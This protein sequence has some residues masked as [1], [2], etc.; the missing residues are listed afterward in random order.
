MKNRKW[1]KK[2]TETRFVRDILKHKQLHLGDPTKWDDKNDCEA[3]R[4]YSEGKNLKFPTL[5][6]CL[7]QAPDRFHFW[8][9][10]GKREFG[11]CLW[12]CK[13]TL[14]ADIKADSTLFSNEV[15]Y[16]NEIDLDKT[17]LDQA[18]FTKREQYKDER[19]FRV[20]RILRPSGVEPDKLAF[21][22]AS[23]K[24]I[25][26]NPWLS[27]KE[28]ETQKLDLERYLTGDLEHVEVKQ[29]RC[30]Q[31]KKWIVRLSDAVKQ[32]S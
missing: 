14:T 13:K 9:I 22:A 19:E 3:L 7:T 31:R 12:F 23:L 29:N 1:L 25:Y 27:S 2:Y 8:H 5:A 11:V 30:L 28:V 18:P 21:S 24:K 16:P 17:K 26:L 15:R 10:F 32:N 6:I 20:I 4:I